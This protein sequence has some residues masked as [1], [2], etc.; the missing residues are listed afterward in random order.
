MG[1]IICLHCGQPA[2]YRKIGIF[3]ILTEWGAYKIQAGDEMK[4]DCG[5]THIHNWS[6]EPFKVEVENVK[7]YEPVNYDEFMEEKN[8]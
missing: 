7:N 6:G 8:D 2:T 5:K 4:C 3:R 1:K